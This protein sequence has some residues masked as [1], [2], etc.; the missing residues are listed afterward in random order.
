LPEDFMTTHSLPSDSS[1]RRLRSLE[2]QNYLI[3]IAVVVLMLLLLWR[4]FAG[5]SAPAPAPAETPAASTTP[6]ELPFDKAESSTPSALAAPGLKTPA[7]SPASPAAASRVEVVDAPNTAAPKSPAIHG[8]LSAEQINRTTQRLVE[9][10]FR[11]P[12]YSGRFVDAWIK[13]AGAAPSGSFA[14]PEPFVGEVVGPTQQPDGYRDYQIWGDG[15]RDTQAQ[16]PGSVWYM[17]LWN[18]DPA[19]GRASIESLSIG[20]KEIVHDWR[21]YMKDRVSVQ[22]E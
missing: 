4:T 21:P 14:F 9:A 5:N 13:R 16:R 17:V 20:G 11:D 2:I 15:L 6:E 1:A 3:K 22:V 8:E 10:A 18:L 12:R 19:S 7:V